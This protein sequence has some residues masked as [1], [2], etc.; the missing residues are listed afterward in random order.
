[1]P[2]EVIHRGYAFGGVRCLHGHSG[3]DV[4]SPG[5][6]LTHVG[7]T[8]FDSSRVTRIFTKLLEN[9]GEVY[10]CVCVCYCDF[11]L[12]EG[13]WREDVSKVSLRGDSEA[14]RRP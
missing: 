13:N 3:V 8:G 2:F 5:F 6:P 9:S 10:V 12:P 4:S 11:L 7:T 1:M 14:D